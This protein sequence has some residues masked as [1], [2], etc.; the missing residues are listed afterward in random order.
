M[1]QKFY[2]VASRVD[3][4]LSALL[5]GSVDK[6]NVSDHFDLLVKLPTSENDPTSIKVNN[7][8]TSVPFSFEYNYGNI[9]QISVDYGFTSICT[10]YKNNLNTFVQKQV[11][12]NETMRLD[13]SLNKEVLL[14]AE[15]SDKP[16][17]A[18]FI[19]F[20][21]NSDDFDYVK[22]YTAGHVLNIRADGEST[23]EF[24]GEQHNIKE[25]TFE[26]PPILS[27]FK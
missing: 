26:Y 22:I 16:R 6:L 9:D 23:L 4:I 27:D 8:S 19:G 2:N 17:L 20:L 12:L 14:V 11:E 21:D 1:P 10:L 13:N 25:S 5:P 3:H 7:I 24:N 18:V 15:C